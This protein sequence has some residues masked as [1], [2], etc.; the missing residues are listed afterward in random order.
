MVHDWSTKQR[1]KTIIVASFRAGG[2]LSNIPHNGSCFLYKLY[3]FCTWL[4]YSIVLLYYPP[5]QKNLQFF[6]SH[7]F[8]K[9]KN[10]VTRSPH[11][12]PPH[13]HGEAFLHWRQPPAQVAQKPLAQQV[14][15]PVGRVGVYS[16]QITII[17]KPELRGFWGDSLTAHLSNGCCSHCDTRR[18]WCPS[19]TREIP[20]L[21]HHLG[22][23]TGGKGRYNL[24]RY[25]SFDPLRVGHMCYVLGVAP[26]QDA[27][28]H[29]DYEPFLVGDPY[30]PSFATVTGRGET[31]QV[32]YSKGRKSWPTF[33]E[34]KWLPLLH[35]ES[36]NNQLLRTGI[37]LHKKS[38]CFSRPKSLSQTLS[39]NV[40]EIFHSP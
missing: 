38:N 35:C 16:G 3:F 23:P 27:S 11:F 20:F 29:Q 39:M 2:F 10:K 34:R 28:D 40:N 9:E 6:V 4:Q 14:D 36:C 7:L 26:S 19:A 21:N 15:H 33:R 25:I 18:P 32:M 8:L 24:P 17:P 22:W 13:P 30:K 5:P 1:S 31:T 37:F 12:R